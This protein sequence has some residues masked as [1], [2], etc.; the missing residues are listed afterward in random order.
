MGMTNY[1]V[2]WS[3]DIDADSPEEAAQIALQYL[4]DEDSLAHVFEVNDGDLTHKVDLDFD[5]VQ[6]VR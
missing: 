6:V 2:S 5:T 1:L 4:K 3:I